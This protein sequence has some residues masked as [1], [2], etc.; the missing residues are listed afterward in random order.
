[1][2]PYYYT[3]ETPICRF[4]FNIFLLF[5]LNVCYRPMHYDYIRAR[6]RSNATVTYYARCDEM[7]VVYIELELDVS[8]R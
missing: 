7:N 1:M 6:M 3:N 8:L 5:N 4:L 2:Q